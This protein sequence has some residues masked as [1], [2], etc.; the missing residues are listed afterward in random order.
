MTCILTI[1][2]KSCSGKT[3]LL[4]ALTKKFPDVIGVLPCYAT[5]NRRVGEKDAS[6]GGEYEFVVDEHFEDERPN[7]F[8]VFEPS[9]DRKYGTTRAQLKKSLDSGMLCA[10]ILEPSSVEVFKQET[11]FFGGNVIS[12]FV[13]TSTVE[14][15]RRMMARAV[16]SGAD[17]ENP[18]YQSYAER[19]KY[20]YTHERHWNRIRR[21]DGLIDGEGSRESMVAHAVAI[22]NARLEHF[23]EKDIKKLEVT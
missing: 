10:R 11:E 18:P 4:H 19:I 17:E 7:M 5:R 3:F 20:M 22:I 13:A 16:D 12:L 14:A 6:R 21:Y 8:Q 2:G 9:P 23:K 15:T 1:T